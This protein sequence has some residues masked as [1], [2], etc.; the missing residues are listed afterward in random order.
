MALKKQKH[1]KRNNANLETRKRR[2]ATSLEY[3][4]VVA[5]LVSAAFVAIQLLASVDQS[6][7]TVADRI[8][9]GNQTEDSELNLDLVTPPLEAA[10]DQQETNLVDEQAII[11][12]IVIGTV[13]CGVF[14]LRYV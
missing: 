5:L 12:M 8:D 2:G 14:A 7:Q 1:F 9:V 11:G 6:F 4:S 10:L 3:I 13:G